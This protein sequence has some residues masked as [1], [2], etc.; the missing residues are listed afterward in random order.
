MFHSYLL[1]LW[2]LIQYNLLA[3]IRSTFL[4]LNLLQSD[5]STILRL[6]FI[7]FPSFRFNRFCP[8][9]SSLSY[10]Q[11]PLNLLSAHILLIRLCYCLISLLCT[12]RSDNIALGWLSLYQ[13]ARFWS[14]FF[15]S[16]LSNFYSSKLSL[17]SISPSSIVYYNIEVINNPNIYF[18][19][20][21]FTI[22]QSLISNDSGILVLNSDP[23]L[24]IYW[25]CWEIAKLILKLSHN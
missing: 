5:C 7:S 16:G 12:A 10:P 19:F 4:N 6:V 2:L 23:Y 1:I 8:L 21:I 25:M 17:G 3:T 22:N 14:V 9:P 18:I 24:H 13:L 11:C 15:S 20:I